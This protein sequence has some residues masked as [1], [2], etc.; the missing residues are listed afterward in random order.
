[1]AAVKAKGKTTI[2]N[3]SIEP[4]IINLVE[5]YL[6]YVPLYMRI[7]IFLNENNNIYLNELEHF[8]CGKY[9]GLQYT[10]DK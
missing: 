8:A 9:Y 7:D 6:G 10:N 4:E 2:Q 3:A 5:N 1:M